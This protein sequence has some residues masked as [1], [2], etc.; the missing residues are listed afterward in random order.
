MPD[1]SNAENGDVT[2]DLLPCDGERALRELSDGHMVI[3]RSGNDFLYVVERAAAYHMFTHTP[4]APGGGQRQ[5]PK[6]EKYTASVKK[7]AELSDAMYLCVFDDKMNLYGVL[8]SAE[9]G[10]LSMFPG[11]NRDGDA[12]IEFLPWDKSRDADAA[13]DAAAPHDGIPGSDFPSE[14]FEDLFEME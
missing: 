1:K 14:R 9:D 11:D 13:G 6:N 4:G 3:A 2:L 10:I 7:L 8:Q 5:F 12:D